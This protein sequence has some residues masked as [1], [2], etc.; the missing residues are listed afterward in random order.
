[1]EDVMRKVI[2][3]INVTLDGC[4]DHEKFE[5]DQEFMD[6]YTRQMR[7][8][9]TLVYGRKIYQMMVPFW[10]QM[11]RDKSAPVPWVGDFAEAFAAVKHIVVFSRTLEQAELPNVRIV[12]TDPAAEIRLLKQEQGGDLHVRGVDIPSQ[13][14]R[15]G[16]VDEF[17]LVVLPVIAGVGPRLMEGLG[18]PGGQKLALAESRTFKSGCIYLRLVK[19]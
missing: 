2:F 15:Q 18:L 17:R 14:M 1:M 10:P 8:V 7:E 16:L 5:P 6:H 13:L 9:E 4:V 12:R 11:A 19:P 3:S